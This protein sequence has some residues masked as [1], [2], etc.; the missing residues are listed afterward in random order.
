MTNGDEN[1]KA[2]KE[3]RDISIFIWRRMVFE[4]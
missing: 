2:R 1:N 3:N 4:C